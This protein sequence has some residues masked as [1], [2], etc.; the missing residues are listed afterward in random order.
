MELAHF[1]IKAI[2]AEMALYE[3]LEDMEDLQD[4]YLIMVHD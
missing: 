4:W 3:P 2:G 1:F